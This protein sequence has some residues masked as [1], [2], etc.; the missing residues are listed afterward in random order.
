MRINAFENFLVKRENLRIFFL[1]TILSHCFKIN[2]VIQAIFNLLSAN[3]FDKEKFNVLYSGKNN[4]FLLSVAKIEFISFEQKGD[5]M[6]LHASEP[7]R[8]QN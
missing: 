3:V 6:S 5:L 7:C 2:A 4:F 1:S 8:L